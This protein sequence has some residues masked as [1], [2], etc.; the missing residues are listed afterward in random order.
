MRQIVNGIEVELTEE[1]EAA[2]LASLPPA[3]DRPPI[4]Q[5]PIRIAC[6]L[7]IRVAGE[8]VVELGGAFRIAAMLYVDTGRFLAVFTQNLGASAPYVIPNNGVSISLSEWGGDFAIIEIR[9]HAGGA[10][11]SPESF[12]FSLYNV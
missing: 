5:E 2:F 3:E 12:G 9:D 8:D 6:V 11:I 7:R 10:L 4:E 1:E